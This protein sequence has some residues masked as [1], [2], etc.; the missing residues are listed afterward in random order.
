MRIFISRQSFINNLKSA[1]KAEKR[2][3]QAS[4]ALSWYL[5]KAARSAG[6]QSWG[7]LHRKLQVASSIEFD[8]IH[9]TIG[10]NIG[11]TFPNAAA[12][13]VEKDVIGCIKSQFERCEEFSAPVSGSQNGYSH[14]SVSIEKEVKS[15]FSGIYPEILLSSAIDRLKDLG[16]WCEDDSEVMFEYEF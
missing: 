10:R 3:S 12:K 11:R 7:W 4:K 2:C 1:A 15:L 14:P 8:H 6:F 13:Y 5:D 9:A 16:P